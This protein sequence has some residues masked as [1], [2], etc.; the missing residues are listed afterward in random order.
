MQSVRTAEEEHCFLDRNTEEEHGESVNTDSKTTVG[1]T[2]VAEELGVELNVVNKSFFGG[3][4]AKLG[5][6]MLTLCARGDLHAAPDKVVALRNAVFVSHV[7]EGALVLR[8]IG[9]EKEL[10]AVKLHSK[11]VRHALRIGGKVA[12]FGFGAGVAVTLLEQAVDLGNAEHGESRGGNDGL[13]AKNT[14]DVLTVLFADASDHVCEHLLLKLHNI[15]EGVDIAELKVKTRKLGGV[16]VGVGFLR[17]EA[18]SALENAL[19]ARRHR[20][21]LVELG[22]LSKVCVSVE[23]VELEYFRAAF[24]CRTDDLR[25]MKLDEAD[26]A[27]ETDSTRYSADEVFSRVRNRIN[28]K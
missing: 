24:T 15:V 12:F 27:A 6:A 9:N 23:I 18:G 11:A 13:Y 22:R 14:L 3:V 8:K 25:E 2:A 26:N 5:I 17:A 19:K 16:L 1:R 10:T 20:H 28:G 4:S 21:L 7:I